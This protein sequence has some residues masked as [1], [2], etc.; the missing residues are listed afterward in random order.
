MA[1]RGVEVDRKVFGADGLVFICGTGTGMTN[2][3]M[4][5][6]KAIYRGEITNWKEL[7]GVNHA[8]TVFYRNDQSGSQ[9]QFE[10]LVWKE[11]DM[12]DFG[13]LGFS[14]MSEMDTIV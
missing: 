11:E 4:D 9:R 12:S 3:S 1:E 8:I 6:L 14:V 2:L 13:L 5:Q 7:G 10:K